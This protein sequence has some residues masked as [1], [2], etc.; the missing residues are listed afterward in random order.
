MYNA[1]RKSRAFKLFLN[2]IQKGLAH[3][4][5]ISTTDEDVLVDFFRLL[6]C[7]VFCEKGTACGECVK[8]KTILD[9]NDPDVI[10]INLEKARIKVDKVKDLV[11]S[12]SIK[13]VNGERKLYYINCAELM[14]RD[15][16]NKLLKTLE[17]PPE[18]VTIFLGTANLSALLDTVKSRCRIIPIDRF[19][20]D[21]V[22]DEMLEITGDKNLSAVAAACSEGKLSQAEKIATSPDYLQ[23]F[24]LAIETLKR[25]KKS[26]DVL[27]F[28]SS[29]EVKKEIDL[30]LEQFFTVLSVLMRDVLMANIDDKLIL[31][32]H[33]EEQISP[34]RSE[35]SQIALSR[36]IF[37]INKA[38]AKLKMNVPKE[39]VL[40]R[41]LFTILE[42]KYKCR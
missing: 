19:D 18:G 7:A 30:G 28:I 33:I 13:P 2:D 21:T 41:L 20:F 23:S 25:V 32:K 36:C 3:A 16:Q 8:C 15:A 35:F 38:K 11:S 40:E 29:A 27:G 26:T 17:E 37:E 5:I 31:S 1:L 9:L 34:L 10:E 39:V 24:N 6:A 12:V 14:A 42:V 4:Y 22:Y